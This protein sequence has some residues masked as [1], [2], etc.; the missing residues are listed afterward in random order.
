MCVSIFAGGCGWNATSVV[1]AC[2]VHHT[3]LC[4]CIAVYHLWGIFW[5]FH[6]C[7]SQHLLQF[8]ATLHICALV[9][10]MP[11]FFVVLA[12]SYVQGGVVSFILMTCGFL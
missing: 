4:A 2:V 9:K 5:S 10:K 7:L 11:L 3:R 1:R 6:V 8:A 12:A